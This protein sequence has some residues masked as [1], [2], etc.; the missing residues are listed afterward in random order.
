MLDM[1][2]RRTLEHVLLA[3]LG[4]VTLVVAPYS[5]VDPINLPKL[6]VLAFF[7]IVAISLVVPVSKKVLATGHRKIILIILL[8]IIDVILI[9]I[10]GASERVEQIYGT[11]GRNSGALAYVSL[12]LVLVASSLVSNGAYVKKFVVTTLSLGVLLAVYG[13]MQNQGWDP[14]PFVNA[15]GSNVFGTFGNPNFMSAF[16]G[17]IAVVS[18]TMVLNT[19]FTHVTRFALAILVVI[20]I[21][22]VYETH[23]QQGYLNF[24]AGVGTVV[25]LWLFMTQR[26]VL[27]AVVAGLGVIGGGLVFLG[28]INAGPLASYLYKASLQARGF[29]WRAGV[30]MLIDHPFF[31]VGMDGFGDWYRRSRSLE[32]TLQS[33]GLVSN[34]AHNVFID[35][36]SN[37][38][39]PLIGIYLAIVGL[40]ITS[41]VRVV[42]RSEGFDV[43]FVA[44]VGAWVAYQ[45]QSFVSINQLGLAIWGWILSGL[46]IGYEINTRTV[47]ISE[48]KEVHHKNRGRSAKILAQPLSSAAVVS[49]FAGVLIGASIALP[50]YVAATQYYKALQSGNTT[51][52]ES[53]AYLKPF[54]KMRFI[55]VATGLRENKLEERAIVVIR[56]AAVKYPDS[57][58]IWS[59]WA[60]IASA[61]PADIANAK[62]Q[63]KRL[64]P[65]NPDLK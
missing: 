53:A 56:D 5:S 18:F 41:I 10:F 9:I 28:L 65:H 38:G 60:S 59:V 31:G 4:F 63:M 26:K 37:G 6:S 57:F 42:Q 47:E 24:V 45:A 15:Y 21:V 14:F 48:S 2:T 12:A 17:L 35:I 43:Y 1:K 20:S 58:E 64:D 52:I 39:F 25:V 40:V 33:P 30:K 34:T 32:D 54:E 16:M 22:I 46:I 36:A 23:A 49:L 27:S 29:Y 19:V 11:F 8:F 50:P 7:G 61:A 44:I 51:V 62:A 55:Q 13:Q 3:G